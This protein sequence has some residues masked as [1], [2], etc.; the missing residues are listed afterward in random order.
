MIKVDMKKGK[1][2]IKG[3]LP[4]LVGETAVIV[5]RITHEEPREVTI[6]FMD[7]ILHSA[8]ITD[9]EMEEICNDVKN[10]RK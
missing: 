4:Q 10:S 6:A 2:L 7:T 5:N 8:N 9:K 1:I 3:S